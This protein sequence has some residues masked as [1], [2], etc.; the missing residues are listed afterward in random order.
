MTRAS[1]ISS[2]D[3]G[4]RYQFQTTSSFPPSN[5]FIVSVHRFIGDESGGREDL[6]QIDLMAISVGRGPVLPMSHEPCQARGVLSAQDLSLASLSA[7]P[8]GGY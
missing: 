8:R 3:P 4:S 6:L 1:S 5:Y 2:I 7:G